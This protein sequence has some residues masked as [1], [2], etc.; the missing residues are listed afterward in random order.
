MQIFRWTRSQIIL[1][2]CYRFLMNTEEQVKVEVLNKTG[3]PLDAADPLGQGRNSNKGDL[4]KRLLVD[5]R[6]IM[7][8]FVP[9]RFK[10]YYRTLLCRLWVIIKIFNSK[11]KVDICKYKEFC[12]FTYNHILESFNNA[13]SRWI[14]IS[15]TLHS[16]LAHS[17]ELIEKFNKMSLGF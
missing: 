3:L 2:K 12:I 11:R 10:E 16:L 7:V 17:W 9:E 14:I 1:G 5:H 6:E 4:C 8:S 13:V 15:P